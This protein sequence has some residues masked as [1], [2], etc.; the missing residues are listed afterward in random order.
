MEEEEKW[1]L[2]F[3]F[4]P[5]LPLPRKK[6]YKGYFSSIFMFFIPSLLII[7]FLIMVSYAIQ[8][9]VF[10]SQVQIDIL[11]LRFKF[12]ASNYCHFLRKCILRFEFYIKHHH[13]PSLSTHQIPSWICMVFLSNSLLRSYSNLS[14]LLLVCLCLFFK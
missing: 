5:P 8:A 9:N 10:I 11:F 2:T 7:F 13:L 14:L 1:M 6:T 12:K 4:N 3:A